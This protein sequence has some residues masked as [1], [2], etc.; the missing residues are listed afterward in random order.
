MTV[1]L[2]I[3]VFCVQPHTDSGAA[4]SEPQSLRQH[5]T[6]SSGSTK[7]CGPVGTSPCSWHSGSPVHISVRSHDQFHTAMVQITDI[8]PHSLTLSS[9]VQLNSQFW[10]SLTACRV[11][12]TRLLPVWQNETQTG[13]W[14]HCWSSTVELNAAT[15]VGV[16]RQVMKVFL[17]S[18]EILWIVQV[19]QCGS[20]LSAVCGQTGRQLCGFTLSWGV[21]TLFVKFFWEVHKS[22]QQRTHS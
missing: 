7:H 21:S 10:R 22:L 18:T 13:P 5:V 17:F 16:Y 6:V 12:S 2:H 9:H 20:G 14:N 4:L 15:A 11:N 1:I 8:Q 19:S 3:S